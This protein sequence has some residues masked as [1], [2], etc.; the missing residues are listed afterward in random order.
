MWASTAIFTLIVCNLALETGLAFSL[1][2][3]DRHKLFPVLAS[4]GVG[5]LVVSHVLSQCHI[6]LKFLCFAA[7]I[8]LRFNVAFGATCLKEGVVFLTLI[9]SI[10]G[11]ILINKPICLHAPQ[12]WN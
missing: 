8:V 12:Q 1:S 9:S 6:T 5:C 7:L 2:Y 4:V 10:A 11:D 3:I